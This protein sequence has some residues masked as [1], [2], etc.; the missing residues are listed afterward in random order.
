MPQGRSDTLSVIAPTARL[1]HY[2]FSKAEAMFQHLSRDSGIFSIHF[3]RLIM[4]LKGA[5]TRRH[6]RPWQSSRIFL[7]TM[8]VFGGDLRPP[9]QHLGVPY[10]TVA[11]Q[12]E[13]R[14]I[15]GSEAILCFSD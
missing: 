12:A 4:K 5:R 15:W 9:G 8:R 11:S 3:S 13:G 1:T 6:D 10:K 14:T 2:I 7:R